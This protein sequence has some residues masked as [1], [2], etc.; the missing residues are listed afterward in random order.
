L[1]EL[2]HH[3]SGNHSFPLCETGEDCSS[4][5]SFIRT[6]KNRLPVRSLHFVNSGRDIFFRYM[7]SKCDQHRG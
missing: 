7:I 3:Q 5:G 1:Q 6:S 2:R 4:E